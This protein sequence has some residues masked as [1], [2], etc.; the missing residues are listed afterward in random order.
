MKAEIVPLKREISLKSEGSL[1]VKKTID[2]YLAQLEKYAGE[3]LIFAKKPLDTPALQKLFACSM[4][5]AFPRYDAAITNPGGF[6]DT[7]K[8]GVV[9]KSDL[10]SIFPFD[11]F[12]VT[13]SIKGEDLAYDLS[14]TENAHCGPVKKKGK[15]FVGGEEID[16][17]KTYKIVTTDFLY[18]GGDGYRFTESEG[19]T[20]TVSWRE[21]L[22]NYLIESSK[23]GFTLEEAYK[24]LY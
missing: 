6:R 22:E 21:P 2:K 16:N 9:K 5:R 12:I 23:K 3:T 15:W 1:E 10:L 18:L 19:V 4:L 14:Q 17:S 8:A 7:I 13:A 24:N 11:N 20:T